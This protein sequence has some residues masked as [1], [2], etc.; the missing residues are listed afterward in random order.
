[1]ANFPAETHSKPKP[2]QWDGEIRCSIEHSMGTVRYPTA[3]YNRESLLPVKTE[4]GKKTTPGV[5]KTKGKVIHLRKRPFLP[6]V[7]SSS[8]LSR[9]RSSLISFSPAN[10]CDSYSE[11]NKSMLNYVLSTL[12]FIFFQLIFLISPTRLPDPHEQCPQIYLKRRS[13]L[14]Q[15]TE[16]AKIL[17]TNHPNCF[18]F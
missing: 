16:Q 12:L 6:S 4:H 9:L 18:L 10:C 13:C 3:K 5:R 8:H 11:A 7:L 1:M 14:T 2:A 17:T 15:C